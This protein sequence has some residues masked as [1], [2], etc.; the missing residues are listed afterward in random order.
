[1]LQVSTSNTT[2]TMPRGFKKVKLSKP[3]T[4]KRMR[5]D[6][7]PLYQQQAADSEHGEEA[8]YDHAIEDYPE[9]EVVDAAGSEGQQSDTN[10]MFRPIDLHFNDDSWLFA[11]MGQGEEHGA[12]QVLEFSEDRQCTLMMP[13]YCP[14]RRQFGC[15]AVRTSE[16]QHTARLNPFSLLKLRPITFSDG[17]ALCCEC[18]NPGCN[19]SAEAARLFAWQLQHTQQQNQTYAEAF[20][21]SP[22]LCRCAQVVL[23]ACCSLGASGDEMPTVQ[24]DCLEGNPV[25]TWYQEQDEW[26]AQSYLHVSAPGL[27]QG[28]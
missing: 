1:V 16:A 17:L 20:G 12:V 2:I 11:A 8:I 18:S 23:R 7:T 25:W 28:L 24:L 3:L 27:K 10:D 6:D 9:D 21:G 4:I 14:I 19:R 5:D 22:A 13:S 26:R 15:E